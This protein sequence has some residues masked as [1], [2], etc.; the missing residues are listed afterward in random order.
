MPLP[1]L[2]T[3]GE[4]RLVAEAELVPG[5]GLGAGAERSAGADPLAGAR[6]GGANLRAEGEAS[7]GGGESVKQR[8]RKEPRC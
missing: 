2:Q 5:A 8:G 4:A 7:L 3:K 1:A 6:P